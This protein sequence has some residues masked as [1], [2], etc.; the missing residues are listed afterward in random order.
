M[1]DMKPG[2]GLLGGHLFHDLL[3]KHLPVRE[4]EKCSIPLGVT[5]F[6]LANFSTSCIQSG[7][8]ASA[9]RASCTFPVLFQP[10]SMTDGLHIDGG[11]FDQYGLMALPG[12]PS[13]STDELPWVIN[14]VFDGMPHDDRQLPSQYHSRCRVRYVCLFPAQL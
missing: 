1:W 9:I 8:L 12:I 7:D 2:L 10:V 6:N 13:R 4:I 3:E 5:A 11:I 14:V